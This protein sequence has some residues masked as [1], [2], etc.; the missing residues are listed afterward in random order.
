M[1]FKNHVSPGDDDRKDG[2]QTTYNYTESSKS[3]KQLHSIS[4]SD[5]RCHERYHGSE[6][7]RGIEEAA[8]VRVSAANSAPRLRE[9]MNFDERLTSSKKSET[10]LRISELELLSASK[11]AKAI[12]QIVDPTP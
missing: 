7:K 6:N 10:C 4:V 9:P 3:K 2:R 12:D 1:N 5:L 8:T 11:N